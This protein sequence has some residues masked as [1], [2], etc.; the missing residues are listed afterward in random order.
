MLLCLR[1]RPA[2]LLLTSHSRRRAVP[3]QHV[4]H[5]LAAPAPVSPLRIDT[6]PYP[7]GVWL[8]V[9]MP[10]RLWRGHCLCIAQAPR[11]SVQ[12]FVCCVQSPR[13]CTFSP[14]AF[15]RAC[16][17]PPLCPAPTH[18]PTH[19]PRSLL[20]FVAPHQTAA[21]LLPALSSAANS[22]HPATH[23]IIPCICIA[24]DIADARRSVQP[25]RSHARVRQ[26]TALHH[27]SPPLEF[28]PTLLT[29]C[30]AAYSTP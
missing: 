16:A 22:P 1:H 5:A 9:M 11:Y 12:C 28:C 6:T 26:S 21:R 7:H 19:H 25:A 20:R 2:P 17:S 3:T 23:R 24:C 18:A 15:A 27:C 13:F 29:S 10:Q 4:A 14:P 30:F 8:H